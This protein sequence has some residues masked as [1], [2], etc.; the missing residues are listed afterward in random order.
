MRIKRLLTGAAIVVVGGAAAVFAILQS[1]DFNSYKDLVAQQVKAATGRDL[2]LAGDVKV[3]LSLIPHLEIDQVSFRNADWGSEPQMLKLEK[4]EADV[5][6]IPLLSSQIQIKQVRLVGAEILLETNK[7][8]LGNWVM[9]EPSSGGSSAPLPQ[10]SQVAIENGKLRWH[11]G[12]TGKTRTFAVDKLT[13]APSD[14]VG[15]LAIAIDGKVDTMPISLKGITGTLANFTQ[16]PL[17]I[18]ATGQIA[19]GDLAIKGEVADPATLKGINL[20]LTLA[21]KAASDLGALFEA[22]LPPL[23]AYQLR[24]KLGN[25]DGSFVFDGLSGK[26]GST[27]FTGRIEI[28]PAKTPTVINASLASSHLDLAD[29]GVKPDE[30][31]ATAPGDG[32]VFSAEP[33]DLTPLQ[34]VDGQFHLNV[35]RAI[36]GS[37]TLDNLVG[38]GTL[39]S[40]ALKVTTLTAGLGDGTLGLAANVNGAVTPA[41][42][43][44]RLRAN[45]VDGAPLLDAMGMGGAVTAGRL[46][47][48][49]AVQGPGSSLRAL[50]AGWNG[51]LHLEMGAGAINNDFARLMF[52]D[53]FQLVTFGGT[54]NAAKVNCMVTD[55]ATVDGIAGAKTLVLDTPGVTVVGSG[56][57]N[58]RDET[59][60]LHFDS[61]S[62]QTNLANLAVPINVGGTLAKPAVSPDA[63]GAVGNTAD[64]A[65][66]TAN[67]ATFGALASLTGV[68]AGT[69]PG[70]N[71]CVSAAAAGA[72]Q[73]AAPSA[74]DKIINGLSTTGEGIGQGAQELGEDALDAGKK[75]GD[76]AGQA[77][78][79]LGKSLFGN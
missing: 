78:D 55:F 13:M 77:I 74:G 61:S 70:E 20:E 47:L 30:K 21:G 33:W 27:D 8:G 69:S 19:G 64:F 76:A 49:A 58:L 6:L 11:N 16:G 54:A 26:L 28:D 45:N 73:S 5:A 41:T 68:G 18:N 36:L 72:K 51:G 53:L 37:T 50:M 43:E 32:K 56:D 62:K 66:R 42:V 71:P 22:K 10:I 46:N 65:A 9:G 48:E 23:G 12:V 25:P 35:Q 4:L 57:V 44:A 38:E 14:A 29:L 7:D 40:G 24:T 15:N 31:K 75:A 1:V 67:S 17:P 79:D 39:E 3:A 60:H 2:V 52:A 59:L 34:A 63:L